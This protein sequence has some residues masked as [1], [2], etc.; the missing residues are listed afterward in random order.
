MRLVGGA[1]QL[2]HPNDHPLDDG[3]VEGWVG[4]VG[5]WVRVRVRVEGRGGLPRAVRRCEGLQGGTRSAQRGGGA[6]A[7]LGRGGA[8]AGWRGAARARAKVTVE[9]GADR[10]KGLVGICRGGAEARE[11]AVE[12]GGEKFRAHAEIFA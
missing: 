3:R 10:A 5:A 2:F 7:G 6:G 12:R 9:E 1:E 4:K 11:A 8:G